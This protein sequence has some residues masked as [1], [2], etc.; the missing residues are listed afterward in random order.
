[1]RH[2]CLEFLELLLHDSLWNYQGEMGNDS[3]EFR[4]YYALYNSM[5]SIRLDMNTFEKI[6][7]GFIAQNQEINSEQ[8]VD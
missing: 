3:F 6:A 2:S 4:F 1:M 5:K 8:I 7:G